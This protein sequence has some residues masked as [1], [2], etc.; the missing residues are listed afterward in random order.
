M[1]LRNLRDLQTVLWAL[2]MP[3]VVAAQYARPEW[4][5]FLS[6]VSCYLA[7]AA[8]V[9]AHNHNHCPTFRS[10]AMNRAFGNWLSVFY[11]YPTFAWIPTHNLNHHKFVNRPGDATITWR[12]TNDHRIAVAV[13]YFFVSSYWQSG[14]INKFLRETRQKNP[15]FF[16]QIMVQYVIWAGTALGLAALAITLH[17]VATGLLVWGLA[18]VLPAFFALWT[19][20]LFNYEQHV[21]ADPWSEHNHSRSW[22]GPVLN[23]LL[24]NNGFHSAHHENPGMHWSELSRAHAG[25][26]RHIDPRLVERNMWWYFFR[27]YFLSL[28]APRFRTQQLGRAPFDEGELAA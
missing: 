7:L 12:Y 6:P 11:G 3:F 23:F 13:T 22:T 8:G 17:G 21:H 19:I 20:M 10:R 18:T 5:P 2:I 26:A 4:L 9:I 14:L 15:K 28:V 16:R 24:F 1:G 27:C 25:L